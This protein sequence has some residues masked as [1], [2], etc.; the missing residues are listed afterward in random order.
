MWRGTGYGGRRSVGVDFD[1]SELGSPS[2]H[3]DVHADP[4]PEQRAISTLPPRRLFC[5]Q[6]RVAGQPKRFVERRLVVADVVLSPG[7]GFVGERVRRDEVPA[8]DLHRVDPQLGREQ[9]D[10]ALEESRS[11][12]PACPPVRADRRRIRDDASEAKVDPRDPV[13]TGRH[14]AGERRQVG[15]HRIGAHVG[16]DVDPKAHDGAVASRADLDLLALRPSMH[17][18]DEILGAGLDVANGTAESHRQGDQHKVFRIGVALSAEAAADV[19]RDHAETIGLEP[20][21]RHRI[22]E[23]EEWRLAREP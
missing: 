14:L 9:V 3:L 20:E 12:R 6:L 23:N 5:P 1:R 21:H 17:H 15:A 13:D 8:A 18:R 22:L 11:L 7:H 16:H 19:G 10:T 4:D 2:C